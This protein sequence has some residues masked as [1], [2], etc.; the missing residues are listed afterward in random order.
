MS[1]KF[2]PAGNS[3]AFYAAGNKS[4][5][6]APEWL[7]GLG[8]ELYEY[9]CGQGVRGSDEMFR[10]MGENAAA[11]GIELSLHAPY[12]ISLSGTE[13]E[14]RLKSIDYIRQSVSA[15]EKMK[16]RIIVIHTGSAAKISREEAVRLAKDTI[17]RA[18][19]AIPDTEVAFGLE[20]MG[21]KNQLGTLEEVLDICSIDG[22]L[23]PVVDFGHLNARNCGGY[24]E[25]EDDYRRIFDMIADKLGADYAENL[26]CHFSKIEYTSSG[27]K[28]HL[29]FED[30]V[31]GPEFEGLA[32]VIAKDGLSPSIIC[33]SDGT[34]AKDALIM[35]NMYLNALSGNN[36]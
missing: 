13:E 35:K 34:M 10:Q 28:K 6:Q 9:Q 27:E 12:F 1:A 20:T 33:E 18:L 4:T 30:N 29:R 16:A 2:G 36:G 8:L 19:N 14:K 17:Y 24:F 21:K 32:E 7:H 31:F 15:A 26:H 11:F 22:R 23:R 25:K 3:E 5:L